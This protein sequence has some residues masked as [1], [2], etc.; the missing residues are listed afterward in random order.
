MPSTRAPHAHCSLSV[1]P[2]GQ[3]AIVSLHGEHDLATS[4]DFRR[5]LLDAAAAPLVILDF[6]ECTFMDSCVM[7]V[8]VGAAKRAAAQGRRLLG[9]NLHGI[10]L[11]AANL[12]GLHGVLALHDTRHVPLAGPTHHPALPGGGR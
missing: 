5:T 12:A 8:I 6:A 4:H 11:A 9:T 7:G 1:S 10:P 3:V 2:T